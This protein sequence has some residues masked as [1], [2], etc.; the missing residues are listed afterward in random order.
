M[1]QER[2][3]VRYLSVFISLL[4][5]NR[6]SPCEVSK[7]YVVDSPSKK[8]ATLQFT[9]KKKTMKYIE[10]ISLQFEGSVS[11][12]DLRKRKYKIRIKFRNIFFCLKTYP[13]LVILDAFVLCKVYTILSLNSN[14]V[15]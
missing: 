12:S 9:L 7:L 10:I 1:S 14:S 6:G 15:H 11:F 8:K 3:G 13:G 5:D 2:P 4:R